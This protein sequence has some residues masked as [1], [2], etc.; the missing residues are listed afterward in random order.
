MEL[1]KD[2]M[3]ELGKRLEAN[4]V[5]KLCPLCGNNDLSIDSQIFSIKNED[6]RLYDFF[7]FIC[8]RCKVTFF[9]PALQYKLRVDGGI[10][11][12]DKTILK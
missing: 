1:T 8:P 9:F 10:Y 4:G 3:L 12:S 5:K 11:P 6:E 2:Q 7:V